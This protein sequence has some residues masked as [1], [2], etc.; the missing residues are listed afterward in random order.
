MA[1]EEVYCTFEENCMFKRRNGICAILRGMPKPR[2][3]GR[4]P[5]GKELMKD[6]GGETP[7][8][9]IKTWEL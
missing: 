4:C 6:I 2:K 7:Y 8:R 5:F 9:G 3:S 1:K